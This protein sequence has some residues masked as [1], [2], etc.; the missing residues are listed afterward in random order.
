MPENDDLPLLFRKA[1]P[2]VSP[3][4]II[5]LAPHD[6]LFRIGIIEP[7]HFKDVFAIQVL[8]GGLPDLEMIHRLCAMRP[9][10]QI[11]FLPLYL[12]ALSVSM[13]LDEKFLKI[14]FYEVFVLNQQVNGRRC[15]PYAC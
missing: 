4:T 10:Q 6:V 15:A 7:E 2:P 14:S 8:I 13:I 9:I 5:G 3:D 11:C 1:G 12:P